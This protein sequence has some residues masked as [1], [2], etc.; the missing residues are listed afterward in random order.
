M[1][2]TVFSGLLFKQ[3]MDQLL[4]WLYNSLNVLKYSHPT[5]LYQDISLLL[6]LYPQSSLSVT[7]LQPQLIKIKTMFGTCTF[8][9]EYP[10]LAPEF[11]T[12]II[13]PVLDE[14]NGKFGNQTTNENIKPQDNRLVLL[15]LS[16]HQNLMSPTPPSIPQKPQL[17]GHAMVQQQNDFHKSQPQPQP[18]LTP[19]LPPNPIRTNLLNS[20][21]TK[22]QATLESKLSNLQSS[23]STNQAKLIHSYDAYNSTNNHI[24]SLNRDI[25]MVSDVVHVK[26]EDANKLIH[27]VKSCVDSDYNNNDPQILTLSDDVKVK[28]EADACLDV[29]NLLQVL[30]NNEKISFDKFIEK[31]RNISRKRALLL[32]ND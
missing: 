23:I 6:A 28:A 2:Y 9:K 7:E 30:Y 26:T 20:L 1:F 32:I 11:D 19:S 13:S 14:W 18:Q 10:K 31:T 17:H 16:I 21:Q 3:T 25:D 12:V 8:P 4:S 24:T 29:L 15:F 27:Y 5:L 22:L